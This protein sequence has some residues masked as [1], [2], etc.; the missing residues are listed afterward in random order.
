MRRG[1]K[2]PKAHRRPNDAHRAN[3][4]DGLDRD[5]AVNLRGVWAY[6]KHGLRQMRQQD[7]GA[8]VHNCSLGG[9]VGLP[10]ARPTTPRSTG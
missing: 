7:S 1:G 3:S 6:M 9:L 8:I 4:A 10:D 2:K 5:E